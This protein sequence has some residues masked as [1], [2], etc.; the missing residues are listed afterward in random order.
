M[1]YGKMRSHYDRTN[2]ETASKLELIILC[3]DKAIQLL[4]QAKNH[5]EEKAFE[6]KSRK[7]QKVLDIINELQGCLDLEQGG[8]VAKNLDAIYTYLTKK[9]LLGDIKA[10]LTA[11]DEV[12]HIM[13]ELKEAWET[14]SS[15]SE[16]QISNMS[17]SNPPKMSATQVAA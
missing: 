17:I 7:L 5:Y 9:I 6:N 10:E 1:T 4:T 3:Y 16:K 11:F 12:L 15:G 8:Q 2:V 13:N 14:I